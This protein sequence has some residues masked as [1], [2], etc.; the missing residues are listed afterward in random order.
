MYWSSDMAAPPPELGMEG[1]TGVLCTR[2]WGCSV[3]ADAF[4]FVF[5]GPTCGGHVPLGLLSREE[6]T[7]SPVGVVPAMVVWTSDSSTATGMEANQAATWATTWPARTPGGVQLWWRAEVP[8]WRR[9]APGWRAEVPGRRRRAPA[10]ERRDPAVRRSWRERRA[11][12]ENRSRQALPRVKQHIQHL[13]R[14]CIYEAGK[15][16]FKGSV[17]KFK[18]HDPC[19]IFSNFT[20]RCSFGAAAGML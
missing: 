1:A 15:G 20:A 18:A 17:K 16:W 12:K 9:R 10:A 7:P 4:F 5:G 14:C 6:G 8:G 19:C 3:A 13:S 11:G 2:A